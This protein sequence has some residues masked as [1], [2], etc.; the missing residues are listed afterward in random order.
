MEE[1]KRRM[2]KGKGDGWLRMRHM[3]LAVGSV[4]HYNKRSF[5]A[6]V[7]ETCSAE[8]SSSGV[9]AEEPNNSTSGSKLGL[10]AGGERVGGEGL[11]QWE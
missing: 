2:K 10:C 9:L 8:R 7:E 3:A 1:K 6:K 4:E 11:R 5:V